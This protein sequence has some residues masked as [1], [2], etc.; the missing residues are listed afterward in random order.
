MTQKQASADGISLVIVESPAKAKTISKFL[1]SNYV[2]EASIG[3][4]RDLPEGAK[5]I[6]EEYK[7]KDWAY[8]GVN[9]DEGFEPVYVVSKDK[10]QQ[11]RKLKTALKSAKE[12]FLATDEDREGE[13]ISWHLTEVLKPKVPVHRL[14]FHEITKEAILGALQSPREIDENLVRAQETRRIIDRLYGYDV[15]PLLWRKVRPS[16]FGWSRAKR[17]GAIDR[18][19]RAAAHGLQKRD[20]LGSFGLIRQVERR[21]FPSRAGYRRRTK[22][23]PKPRFRSGHR[24]VER[25][26]AR[27]ARR[28]IGARTARQ[29]ARAAG[30]SHRTGRQAIHHAS[31]CAVHDEHAATG[32]QPQIRI[33]RAAHHAARTVPLRERAHYLHAYRLDEPGIGSHRGRAVDRVLAIR[34]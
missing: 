1:G 16:P 17:G 6:P 23:P 27:P 24:Q 15:S 33:H 2:I 3:H 22:N 21:K 30:E 12:L 7:T 28:K 10:M 20:L 34:H 4:I 29:V 14:V 19:A 18:R 32:R 31:L 9:V 5:E 13:A 11:V 25:C 8:L 26:D